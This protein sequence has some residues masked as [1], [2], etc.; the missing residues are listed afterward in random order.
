MKN[1]LKGISKIS[2]PI[3]YETILK[4]NMMRILTIL[5]VRSVT[6]CLWVIMVKILEF[7]DAG[8]M[9][10]YVTKRL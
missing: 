9:D 3:L 8:D 4:W 1:L 2:N 10:L 6:S 5:S 7:D